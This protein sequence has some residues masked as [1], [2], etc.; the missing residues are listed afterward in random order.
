MT[1]HDLINAHI[2]TYVRVF[3]TDVTTDISTNMVNKCPIKYHF[4][5]VLQAIICIFVNR[6]RICVVH[7]PIETPSCNI[8]CGNYCIYVCQVKACRDAHVLLALEKRQYILALQ[9]YYNSTGRYIIVLGGVNSQSSIRLCMG[10]VHVS[11]KWTT[12][13][14]V[15]CSEYRQASIRFLI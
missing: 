10:C 14:H 2:H 8:K 13:G 15:S 7:F 9:Q 1:R 11:I 12:D 4:I 6:T 3:N 5:G